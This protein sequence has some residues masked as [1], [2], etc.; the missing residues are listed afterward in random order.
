MGPLGI[1]IVWILLG[2]NSISETEK[3]S[4]QFKD[5]PAREVYRGKPAPPN[6]ITKKS[7]EYRT[8]IREGASSKVQFA[9]HYTVP[10]WGCGTDCMEFAIVDSISGKVY[11]EFWLSGLPGAWWKDHQSD[12]DE[13]MRY[14]P[15]SRL[16]KIQGCPRD[17]DCGFY[18]YEIVDG[19]GL[20]LIWKRLLPKQYQP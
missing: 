18:Y 4:P 2:Q 10:I 17:H 15:D 9:G 1:M 6:I 16:L 11:D 5:Y 3:R 20:R 7:R 8:M 12:D 13:R 14:L 19:E